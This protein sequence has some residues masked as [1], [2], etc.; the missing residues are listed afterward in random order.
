MCVRV[1]VTIV[2]LLLPAAAFAQAEKRIALLIGNQGYGSEIGRLANPHND[3]AILE[4]QV[5]RLADATGI[6][7]NSRV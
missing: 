3:V 2:L 5:A 6:L 7:Q 1:V 4:P